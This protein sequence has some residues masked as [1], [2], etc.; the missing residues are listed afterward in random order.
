MA[1]RLSINEPSSSSSVLTSSFGR[2]IKRTFDQA[3]LHGP[4]S[5]KSTY[6][7]ATGNEDMTGITTAKRPYNFLTHDVIEATV[8]CMIAQ[9]DE[10][11]RNGNPQ[12]EAER[13]ILEEFGR[14]L[15]EIIDFSIKNNE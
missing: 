5:S 12:G 7:T 6:R 10:C 2:P 15:V 8:Q 13:M 4:S 3:E 11:Q 14:C 9:A 1:D